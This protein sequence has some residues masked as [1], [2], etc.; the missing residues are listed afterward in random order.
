MITIKNFTGTN[1]GSTEVKIDVLDA[2]E[3]LNESLKVNSTTTPISS[4]ILTKIELQKNNLN[5][6]QDNVIKIN[7]KLKEVL[8]PVYVSIIRLN[9]I[10]PKMVPLLT[11]LNIVS[12]DITTI[13]EI[14]YSQ[15]KGTY[16]KVLCQKKENVYT[17]DMMLE[18]LYKAEPVDITV[19][20]E[21]IILTDTSKDGI[22]DIQ[23]TAK[24]L[25]NYISGL[26][27]PVNNDRMIEYMKNIHTEALS[28]KFI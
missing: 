16:V 6:V 4:E 25:G 7:K 14:D 11:A 9:E 22:D 18:K 3:Q 1:V 5:G 27:L 10:K 21:E 15:Y 26:T 12:E 2:L 20:E 23:D 17:F 13:N 24:I 28:T 8:A 19:L